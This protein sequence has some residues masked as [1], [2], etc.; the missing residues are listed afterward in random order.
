ML[1]FPVLCSY[2]WEVSSFH[3]KFKNYTVVIPLTSVSYS[4]SHNQDGYFLIH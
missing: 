2:V 4:C 1:N 3:Y